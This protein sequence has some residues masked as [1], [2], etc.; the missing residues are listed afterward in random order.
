MDLGNL[1][2]TIAMLLVFAIGLPMALRKRTKASPQKLQEFLA[3]LQKM[4]V[5]ALLVEGDTDQKK[6]GI[7]RGSGRRSEGLIGIRERNID[8]VNVT[9]VATQYGVNYS[10]DFLVKRPDWLGQQ[11]RKKT[12]MVRKKGS[13]VRG[14]TIDIGWKG[15]DY[16]SQTLTLD[17]RLKDKLLEAE[18]GVLKGG[19]SIFPE[20]KQ[21]YSR[22]R[23]AYLLPSSDMFEAIDIIAGH[24]KSGW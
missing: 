15:D 17:Y 6:I 16:L 5:E 18:P 24:I 8:Y 19:I 7:S 11:K 10:L 14:K 22:V 1:V 4:G 21:D 23:T 13:A 9:S 20:T 2:G 3:H 12:R